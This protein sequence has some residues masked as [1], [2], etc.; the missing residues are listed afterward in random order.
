VFVYPAMEVQSHNWGYLF[1]GPVAPVTPVL[2]LVVP[3][4]ALLPDPVLVV[5]YQFTVQRSGDLTNAVAVDAV[6]TPGGSPVPPGSF[7][8]DAYPVVHVVVPAGQASATASFQL[9][10]QGHPAADQTVLLTLAN[11]SGAVLGG[12]ISAVLTLAGQSIPT[13]DIVA[14]TVSDTSWQVDQSYSE[15]TAM[16]ARTN[17][18][19]V[20]LAGT[21]VRLALAGTGTN[22]LVA[23]DIEGGLT[24]Q[25]VA[26]PAGVTGV[27]VVVATLPNPVSPSPDKTGRLS[28]SSPVGAQLS[29]TDAQVD[30]ALTAPGSVTGPPPPPPP[31]VLPPEYTDPNL[32][33]MTAQGAACTTWAQ[34]DA[35]AKLISGT[36]ACKTK[37]VQLAASYSDTASR[38]LGYD[39]WTEG[40]G[41]AQRF[42]PLYI[43]GPA[44]SIGDRSAIAS[45][46]HF[47]H[48]TM[49]GATWVWLHGLAAEFPM[50]SGYQADTT[51]AID[52][53]GSTDCFVTRCWLD[54]PQ[55]VYSD[56]A[57]RPRIG[58]NDFYGTVKNITPNDWFTQMRLDQGGSTWTG[59]KGQKRTIAALIYQ[60]FHGRCRPAL[61]APSG[62]PYGTA[63]MYSGDGNAP[64]PGVFDT[65]PAAPWDLNTR[66]SWYFNNLIFMDSNYLIY[67]KG[68]I[69]IWRNRA[70]STGV[71]NEADTWD[72]AA[73]TGVRPRGNA[74]HYIA[75]RGGNITSTR[76]AS[77]YP[78]GFTPS[79]ASAS[80]KYNSCEGSAGHSDLQGWNH[81]IEFNDWGD[82]PVNLWMHC[83]A[84][85]DPP[86]VKHTKTLLATSFARFRGNKNGNY[87]LG[88]SRGDGRYR[89][90]AAMLDL[91][92]EAE[93]DGGGEGNSSWTWETSYTA[94]GTGTIAYD[95]SGQAV[96]WTGGGLNRDRLQIKFGS[97]DSFHVACAAGQLSKQPTT[98][99]V[100]RL[101]TA[102]RNGRYAGEFTKGRKGITTKDGLTW[103]NIGNG[104]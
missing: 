87:Q 5:V 104:A 38:N 22:P 27:A 100:R 34:L 97:G 18:G 103:D 13:Q 32:T 24:N 99:A 62:N 37:F 15:H 76:L 63:C 92:W 19:G 57:V 55:G 29:P 59:P 4:T 41:A 40:S 61:M 86:G 74:F 36:A 21:S 35:A 91:A 83:H 89:Y 42:Y 12:V 77:G 70:V 26:F 85:D 9:A 81:T 2:N 25:V 45:L 6:V 73:R 66:E 48:F 50:A 69:N 47:R 16:V 33:G 56:T 64:D 51:P 101:T 46:P 14:V 90:Y 60:N 88:S 31:G 95:L 79:A 11:P 20:Y 10:A 43:V 65:Y 93:G 52:L 98:A 75:T 1:Q 82:V 84:D 102:Y 44:G 7:V 78:T 49:T 28:L 72:G 94:S 58:G 39:G 68:V 80:I 3:G 17:A 30:V 23:A 53:G 54:A 67:T 96:A 71:W 8:G